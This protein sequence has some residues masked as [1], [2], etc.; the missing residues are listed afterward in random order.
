MSCWH[1]H[2]T[3]VAAQGYFIILLC[4]KYEKCLCLV[5][6]IREVVLY[7]LF[8]YKIIYIGLLDSGVQMSDLNVR[9][10]RI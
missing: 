1:R 4:H 5:N 8:V 2:G 10:C 3:A 7:C 6:K 9:Q